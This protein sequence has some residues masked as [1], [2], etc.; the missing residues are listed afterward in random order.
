MTYLKLASKNGHNYAN[1]K[2]INAVFVKKNYASKNNPSQK[3]ICGF[4]Q[5]VSFLTF[6]R[7]EIEIENESFH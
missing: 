7:R 1:S 5:D 6:L 4:V 2:Y 3:I